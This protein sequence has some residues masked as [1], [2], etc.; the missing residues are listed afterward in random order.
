MK[1]P[2]SLRPGDRVGPWTIHSVLGAGHSGYVYRADDA[3]GRQAAIKIMFHSKAEPCR[4]EAERRRRFTLEGETAARLQHPDIA[5]IWGSGQLQPTAA[6]PSPGEWHAMEM[7]TGESLQ[8]HITPESLLPPAQVLH[9]VG[10]VAKAL[11]YAHRQGVVHRDV[12]PANIIVDR[13]KGRVKLIDFGVAQSED[14]AQTDTGMI[15]GSPRYMAPEQILGWP[16]DPRSDLYSLGVV[17]YQAISGEMPYTATQPAE[18]FGEIVRQAHIPLRLRRPD[19]PAALED[20]IDLLLQKR[21]ELRAVDGDSLALELEA[22]MPHF[23]PIQSDQTDVG[24]GQ[25]QENT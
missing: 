8:A 23:S 25:N 18:L 11:A 6:C 21:P 17:L 12:K 7:A 13:S 14:M 20:L 3:E 24:L 19:L 22:L 5:A 1:S 9:I 10:R 16:T 4:L 15:V 2:Y